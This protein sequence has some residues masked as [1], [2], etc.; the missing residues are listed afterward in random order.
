M[1]AVLTMDPV[2]M[3]NAVEPIQFKNAGT[4]K[5]GNT[6]NKAPAPDALS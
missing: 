4:A 6:A 2:S 3:K 5:N 1:E